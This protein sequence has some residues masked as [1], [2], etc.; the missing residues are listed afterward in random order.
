MR[1][2]A[3][4]FSSLAYALMAVAI[5]LVF[6]SGAMAAQPRDLVIEPYGDPRAIFCLIVFFSS[7]LLVMT[8]E[9]THLRK[10]KPVMLGA[11][12]IWAVI[13]LAAPEYGVDHEQLREAVFHDLGEYGSLMLFLMA[14][15][16]YIS[17]LEFG[18]VFAAL[19]SRLV[20]MGLSYRQLFWATGIIAFFLSPVADNM[21]TA[22]V[23][24]AVVM[25]VGADKPRFA[26][27]A[28]VNIVCAVNAGGAFSPF[29]DITTLMVWQA[30]RVEFVEL[31]GFDLSEV[32][33]KRWK[34]LWLRGGFPRR[35]WRGRTP[36]ADSGTR[37][38][39]ARSSN[40]TSRSSASRSRPRSCCAPTR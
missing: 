4:L 6:A 24:G 2:F 5:A 1:F 16:I 20:G 25:A 10:S 28:M 15:M 36:I 14:A 29:G 38:S 18:N 3:A 35:G 17:A 19:R 9:Q 7:Y 11:G 27:V 23:M 13:G 21:T 32:T 30:G 22:L 37:S 34:R 33:T 12:I 26:T 39:F 40:A 31:S 8:E